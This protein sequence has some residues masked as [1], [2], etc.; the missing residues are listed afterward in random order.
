MF[1]LVYTTQF[2]SNRSSTL[3]WMVVGEKILTFQEWHMC[4]SCRYLGDTTL[5]TH[6]GV[7][8][9]VAEPLKRGLGKVSQWCDLCG[10]K[11]NASK[12]KTKI[13][14]RSRT[15]HPQS[16]ILT[17]GGTVLKVFSCHLCTWF[18]IWFQDNFWEAS[19]LSVQ[20]SYFGIL[21]YPFWSIVLRCGARCWCTPYA[22][23]LT[24]IARV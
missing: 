2:L 21:S 16:P 20:S 7:R 18:N 24:M 12:T 3:W 15:M 10:M 17:I 1:C 23:L 13:V 14:S 22:H 19:S 9:V 4:Y 11:F 5:T 6:A 8:I